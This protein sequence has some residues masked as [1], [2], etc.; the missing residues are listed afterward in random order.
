MRKFDEFKVNINKTKIDSGKFIFQKQLDGIQGVD[1]KVNN[2]VDERVIIYNS[3]NPLNQNK[4][5]RVL[6]AKMEAKIK[7]GD[8]ITYDDGLGEKT[9][10]II[11]GIDSHYVFKKARLRLCNQTLMCEGQEKPLLCVAD[12]TTYGT[13]GLDD[14]R[15]F[16]E[17]DSRLKVW[18]QKNEISD[19]YV[20]NMKFIFNHSN[21]YKVTRIDNISMENIY[22]MEMSLVPMNPSADNSEENIADN[23]DVMISKSKEELKDINIKKIQ[24]GKTVLIGEF[25]NTIQVKLDGGNYAELVREG[26]KYSIKALK[27]M[28]YVKLTIT[29][30]KEIKVKNI[31]IY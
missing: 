8:Y 1:V 27:G 5:E 13:K 21:V 15:Y 20:V 28:G 17:L 23:S 22:M 29:N 3:L 31:L 25:D 16:E 26:N 30:N 11:S 19:R 14:N 12:N 18:V 9:Y 10:M 6:E 2:E 4:E 7:R 24:S